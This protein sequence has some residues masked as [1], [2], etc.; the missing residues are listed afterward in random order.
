MGGRFTV[1]DAAAMSTVR[2]LRKTGAFESTS[3]QRRRDF[4]R[5][6]WYVVCLF[7]RWHSR[8]R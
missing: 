3:R 1:G 6:T 7:W 2:A 5:L 4:C 8:W